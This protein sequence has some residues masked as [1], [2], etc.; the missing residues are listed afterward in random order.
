MNIISN[1][2][3][4]KDFLIL[5]LIDTIA[6]LFTINYNINKPIIKNHLLNKLDSLNILDI[7][8]NHENIL[9]I[10]NNMFSIF[11]KE[12]SENLFRNNISFFD[13]FINH[14]LLGSGAYA[15]VYKVYNPLDDSNY[16]IKKIGIKGN[17]Y[18]SITELRSMAKL[19]HKNIVRYYTSWIESIKINNAIKNLDND[20][21]IEENNNT[22]LVKF[23]NNFND[24][25]SISS[26]SSDYDEED[27]DKFI[28]IQMELCK[29]NLKDYL[30]ENKLS[31]EDKKI[32]C[33][34]IIDGIKFIHNN[35][36]IH[37]DLK[38]TNIFIDFNNKIK[39]GDFGL[40]SNI[41]DLNFDEVG[42]YGYIAPEIINGK[43]YDYK[44]DLYSLGVILLEIFSEFETE[45]EKMISIKNIK[46]GKYLFE[47]NVL[48][49]IL[50]KLIN[51]NPDERL[52]LNKIIIN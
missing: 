34:E 49:N 19:T 26:E 1:K 23:N 48:N 32:I 46:N 3:K 18:Q 42:T 10:K 25:N 51:D 15:N 24:I 27:Y 14:E 29:K 9:E 47:N 37:R 45:M 43:N 50:S 22:Q 21:T 31:I 6:D 8:I 30:E 41:Y 5:S 16:A 44:V 17:F 2:D 7:D 33:K 39:I 35:N 52:D 20:I 4:I 28:F 11:T 13:N 12:L 38:L 40:A 36:I